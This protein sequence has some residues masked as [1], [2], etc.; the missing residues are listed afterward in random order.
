MSLFHKV[1][2]ANR[3]EIALRIIRS[4]KEMGIE[5]V[6]VFSKADINSPHVKA[7][8]EAVYIGLAAADESYLS[9]EKILAAAKKTGATMVHPGYGFLSENSAFAVACQEAGLIF[10]G[11][12]ADVIELMGSK[13]AAKKTAL[14]AGVPC[15]P[16]YEDSDQTEQ[17]FIQ[18]AER[19]GYPV[20]IKASYGGGGRG[21]R[22]VTDPKQLTAQLA[23]AHFE[24]KSA[25]ANG[26]LI[27]EKALINARHIEIQIFADTQGNVVH[28]GERDCSVQ[29][30]HQKVLEESPSPF[31]TDELRQAMGQAAIKLALNCNY[32]GAGTVE[33]LVDDQANFY[34]LE[35]NT[36]LQVEHTVTEM[37]TGI[38]LVNW[39]FKIACQQPLP[40]QQ[41]DI[42][43]RGHA[44]EMRL[45]AEDPAQ[46]F[47]PQ[48]GFIHC[49]Q[50]A[51]R[52]GLRFD[53]GIGEGVEVSSHYDPM[54]AKIIAWGEDRDS[55]LR[56]LYCGLKDTVLLGVKTNKSYIL[57]LLKSPE[58][59][60]GSYN[61]TMMEQCL[62][63]DD[64]SPR[65]DISATAT[66]IAAAIFHAYHANND[67]RP[68]IVP[69]PEQRL[70]RIQ[71]QTMPI[72]LTVLQ[73]SGH[74]EYQI[75]N[76]DQHY[77]IKLI[78]CSAQSCHIIIDDLSLSIPFNISANTLVL[79]HQQQHFSYDDVSY[80]GQALQRTSGDNKL[81]AAMD[82]IIVKLLCEVGDTVKAGQ[83]VL[84]ME[85]MK[86]E[87]QILAGNSGTIEAILAQ[88]GE[89]VAAQQL[90]ATLL[91]E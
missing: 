18:E 10:I 29:R 1:L 28:L 4:A 26:E 70:L 54:L 66:A 30:R 13:S 53:H 37:V 48:T 51:L 79:E 77:S 62:N 84:I 21:M 46:Q 22:V 63:T 65:E 8:D 32:T 59:S 67:Q 72:E 58:F 73:H 44:I 91:V 55:A 3:G 35:M 36:R 68:A 88:P 87:H 27:L 17:R 52:E 33:F 56:R 11:P 80:L 69:K 12:S 39:Q 40:L 45:Y 16:G 57:D 78:E 20:M 42:T 60:S 76:D 81:V 9:I 15:I 61:T 43:Q 75:Q 14:R 34:F 2:I 24:A 49:W 71:Q 50:P 5:T 41:E 90:L 47:L 82:G 25:F 89:S 31:V 38:D 74:V 85:A 6:A 86:M 19:I 64:T 23:S 7:A 83:P